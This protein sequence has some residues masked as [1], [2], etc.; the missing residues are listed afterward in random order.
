MINNKFRNYYYFVVVTFAFMLC[1]Y[2]MTNN[3]NGSYNNF[4][5]YNKT[6]TDLVIVK[7]VE[8]KETNYSKYYKNEYVDLINE[9]RLNNLLRILYQKELDY[10]F[11]SYLKGLGILSFE[12]IVNGSDSQLT[13]S[14]YSK[15]IQRY[16]RINKK[17]NEIQIKQQ[18]L[19][20]L[21]DI[22]HFYSS[23][24]QQLNNS[25]TKVCLK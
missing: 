21:F 17:N 2:L 1:Y 24:N 4:E 14:K 16:L 3:K 13:Q 6:E 7:K 25:K 22:F 5:Y 9:D 19:N 8:L 23:S 11:N 18:F 20:D 12:T 15:E 10:N